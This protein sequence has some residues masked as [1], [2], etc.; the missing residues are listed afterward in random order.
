M[1]ARKDTFQLGGNDMDFTGNKDALCLELVMQGIECKEDAEKVVDFLTEHKKILSELERFEIDTEYPDMP[2]E[3]MGLTIM[4]Y[5]Y[6]V[7]IKTVTIAIIALLLD[8]KVTGGLAATL[9]S[10]SGS[11]DVGI[12]KLDEYEGEKCIVKETI[13]QDEKVGEKDILFKYHGEC[14]NCYMNCKYK[15]L[16]QCKCSEDSIISIYE[17]L[18]SKNMFIKRGEKFVY[19]K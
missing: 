6:Y 16:E 11:S 12:I 3:A 15:E 17:K 9:L 8:I 10:L 19:Q 1:V 14:C 13:S 18:A 5:S 4:D 2:S 7:N